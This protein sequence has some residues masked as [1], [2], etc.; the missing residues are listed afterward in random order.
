MTKTL[1]ELLKQADEALDAMM[2]EFRALDLPYGSKAYALAK[3]A[4]LDIHAAEGLWDREFV[5]L[6]DEQITEMWAFADSVVDFA[7]A[8]EAAHGITKE[9]NA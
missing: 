2:A 4:R 1:T 6:T 5:C 9:K 8:I 7:R 3:D